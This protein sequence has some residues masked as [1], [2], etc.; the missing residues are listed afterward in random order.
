MSDCVC[1]ARERKQN[2]LLK[3]ELQNNNLS[4]CDVIKC[5]TAATVPFSFSCKTEGGKNK[6]KPKSNRVFWKTVG[7]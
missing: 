3:P 5:L 2:I 1:Q 4:L 7:A 6:R